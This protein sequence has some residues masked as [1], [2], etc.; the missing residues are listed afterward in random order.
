MT[1]QL[2]AGKGKNG[3]VL[4]NGGWITYEHALCLSRSPRSDG[5]P[6]P[7]EAPL[8]EVVKDVQIPRIVEEAEGAAIIEVS[9]Y[10]DPSND[11]LISFS[12]SVTDQLSSST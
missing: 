3:L 1:R 12:K 10:I 2:R 11:R 8:P 9:R 4:A 7:N 6:Y 5:L